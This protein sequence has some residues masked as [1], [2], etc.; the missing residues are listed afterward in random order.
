MTLALGGIV[1]LPLNTTKGVGQMKVC[2]VI[3]NRQRR[4]AAVQPSVAVQQAKVNGV[5]G[6]L[7]ASEQQQPPTE[8]DMVMG[9]R[10]YSDLKKLT[11]RNYAE[12]LRQLLA[13]AET[14]T[15]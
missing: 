4:T 14:A 5:V 1:L 15:R 13:K 7:A 12:H 3:G 9:M 8:M 6:Q 11:D 10:R 2:E